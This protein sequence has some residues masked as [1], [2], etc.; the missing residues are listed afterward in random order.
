MRLVLTNIKSVPKD[1]LVNAL[2]DLF[3]VYK[4]SYWE[5]KYDE[6]IESNKITIVESND[7]VYMMQKQ[8]YVREH[9]KWFNKHWNSN[10]LLKVKYNEN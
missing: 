9:L 3:F 4:K 6:E 2:C 8:I 1:K 7:A 5:K 10:I